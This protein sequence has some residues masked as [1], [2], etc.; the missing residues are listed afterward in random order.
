M[1]ES[2]LLPAELEAIQAAIRDASGSRA[3]TRPLP[4][5]RSAYR[6]S[7]AELR[8]LELANAWAAE[9]ARSLRPALPGAWELEVDHVEVLD[10]APLREELDGGWL[11]TAR[12]GDAPA[13]L[14]A[15]DGA[16]VETVAARRCGDVRARL[17]SRRPP[18][19]AALALFDASGAAVL[20]AWSEAWATDHGG[21]LTRS[22]LEQDLTA[23]LDEPELVCATLGWRG[24]LQGS[25]RVYVTPAALAPE[26][27]ATPATP[28]RG[29]D[30]EG[31]DALAALAHVAIEVRVELGALQ[32]SEARTLQLAPGEVLALPS[33][34]DEPVPIF[35]GGV[36]KAWGTP[37]VQRGLLSVT[38][39]RLEG[40]LP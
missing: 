37:V 10:G 24:D 33:Q 34:L 4:L 35:V 14:L 13:L 5:L 12:L 25:C 17:A 16:V 26:R 32:L 38:V 3:T 1:N 8:L 27:P 21:E 7:A 23:L 2:A 9:A 18:T 39:D 20:R 19:R 22:P 28:A 11:A 31:E 36:L 30:R 40:S 15:I 29:D 6:R